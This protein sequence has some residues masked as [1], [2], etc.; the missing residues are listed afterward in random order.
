MPKEEF[1]I[2]YFCTA[3]K[4]VYLK[5]INDETYFCP[6]PRCVNMVKRKISTEGA[7]K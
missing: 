1:K 4:C 2:H 7:K 6:F 3:K 5:K